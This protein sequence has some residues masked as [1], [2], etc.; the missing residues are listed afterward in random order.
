MGFIKF[1]A[2]QPLLLQKLDLQF[3][4]VVDL[5]ELGSFDGVAVLELEGVGLEPL[6]LIPALAE[7][8]GEVVVVLQQAAV[9]LEKGI[10]FELELLR[11][12][13]FDLQQR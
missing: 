6:D 7:F 2:L 11:F 9:L 4:G 10:V 8:A 1:V 12:S 3:E 13:E 5:G